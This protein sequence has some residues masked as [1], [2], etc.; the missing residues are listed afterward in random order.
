[1]LLPKLMTAEQAAVQTAEFE[2]ETMLQVNGLSAEAT[3]NT[4]HVQGV[5]ILVFLS[6][7]MDEAISTMCCCILVTSGYP[8]DACAPASS[9]QRAVTIELLTV[10]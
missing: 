3:Q 5:T 6:L 1:L 10:I 2:C 4:T 7:I 8:K 9:Y